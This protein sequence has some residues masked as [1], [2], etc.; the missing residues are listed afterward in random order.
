MMY[1]ILLIRMDMGKE[2]VSRRKDELNGILTTD[3]TRHKL[4]MAI[5]RDERLHFG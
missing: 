5:I 4:D 3:G 2:T 1:R